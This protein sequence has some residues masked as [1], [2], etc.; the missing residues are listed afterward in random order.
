MGSWAPDISELVKFEILQRAGH[1]RASV[2]LRQQNGRSH[3]QI[4][5]SQAIRDRVDAH[6]WQLIKGVAL[7]TL[8]GV[9]TEVGTG[10]EESEFVRAM[11]EAAQQNGAR[12]GDRLVERSIDI[13]PTV[14]VR[15]GWP[16]RVLVHKDLVLKPW[17]PR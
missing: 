17:G 9:G 1:Q 15:P 2:C 13:R 8:L 12:A 3:A 16:V 6:G 11:R 14:V 10:N 7:S 4:A 5:S